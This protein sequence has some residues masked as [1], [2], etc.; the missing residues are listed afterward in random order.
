MPEWQKRQLTEEQKA[1][2]RVIDG[3][4]KGLSEAA[5]LA[6]ARIVKHGREKDSVYNRHF[7]AIRVLFEASEQAREDREVLRELVERTHQFLRKRGCTPP[8][9]P[10]ELLASVADFWNKAAYGMPVQTTATRSGS[11]SVRQQA[12]VILNVGASHSTP[13]S[14]IDFMT[15]QLVLGVLSGGNNSIVLTA[16]DE[17]PSAI[18]WLRDKYGLTY[19]EIALWALHRTGSRLPI[20]EIVKNA[21]R[22]RKEMSDRKMKSGSGQKAKRSAR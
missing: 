19:D 21:A 13:A 8:W 17:Y 4:L 5:Q 9:G 6:L 3:K 14:A 11:K 10:D 22:L 1:K 20:T 7:A 18:A 2:L 12:S 16:G 15:S